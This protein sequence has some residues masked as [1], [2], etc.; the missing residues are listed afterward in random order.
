MQYESYENALQC[1]VTEVEEPIASRIILLANDFKKML[2]ERRLEYSLEN[3]CN[4][5]QLLLQTER[6]KKVFFEHREIQF[7]IAWKIFDRSEIREKLFLH[8]SCTTLP[9]WAKEVI[10]KIISLEPDMN[11]KLSSC[12]RCNLNL[13]F[14][15][16]LSYNPC[17]SVSEISMFL[18]RNFL[19]GN[20]NYAPHYLFWRY[21]ALQQEKETLFIGKIRGLRII[22]NLLFP[23]DFTID[24]MNFPREHPVE[25]FY[26]ASRKIIIDMQ[27]EGYSGHSIPEPQRAFNAFGLFLEANEIWYSKELV[28]AWAL[29]MGRRFKIRMKTQEC[30]L[31][32]ANSHMEGQMDIRPLR[33]R[34]KGKPEFPEWSQDPIQ[35]YLAERVQDGLGKRTIAMDRYCLMRLVRFLDL[36]N[37]KSFESITPKIVKEFNLQDMDH[38]TPESKNAYNTRIRG[39][40]RYLE[41]TRIIPSHLTNAIPCSSAI[42]IRPVQVL[43]AEEDG[44]LMNAMNATDGSRTILR[45]I[46]IVKLERFLGLRVSDALS[47]RF[48]AIDIPHMEIHIVQKKTHKQLVLPLPNTVLNSIVR[49]VEHERPD[50]ESE[51]I[52]LTSRHPFKPL[53]SASIPLLEHLF[54]DRVHRKNHILRKTLSTEM[55]CSGA[56]VSVIADT[57]GHSSNDSVAKYLD[58]NDET[59]RLCCLSLEGIE[60]TGEL[61]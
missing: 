17:D 52:F 23:S 42:S 1:I 3:A 21:Y 30:Y 6:T 47:L 44:L 39:F 31:L 11:T 48:Q 59:M 38:K 43:S 26:M 55:L 8:A 18:L 7:K 56:T 60:Y 5:L 27:N 25:E 12:I 37:I 35:G 13:F 50:I 49:Y 29:E 20:G 51:H 28:H 32:L 58:T 61:L 36:L 40:L 53:Q 16:L 22:R 24:I 45:D 4:M 33:N 34:G 54:G 46:A 57:L 15:Q 2:D 14:G 19:I 9:I 10:E 41:R